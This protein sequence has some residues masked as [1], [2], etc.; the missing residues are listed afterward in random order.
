MEGSLILLVGSTAEEP[1]LDTV[2]KVVG[3]WS[4][5][6]QAPQGVISAAWLSL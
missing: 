4:Q 3:R 6:Q 5:E 2:I 1:V